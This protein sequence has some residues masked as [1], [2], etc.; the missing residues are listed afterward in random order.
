MGG[1]GCVGALDVRWAVMR[2]AGRPN[3]AAA[4]DSHIPLLSRAG[5]STGTCRVNRPAASLRPTAAPQLQ[6]RSEPVPAVGAGVACNIASGQ[7]RTW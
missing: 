7:Q 1:R 2:P 3:C 5:C 4:C 6:H